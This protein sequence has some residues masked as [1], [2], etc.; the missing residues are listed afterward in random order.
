[1]TDAAINN[2]TTNAVS[3]SSEKWKEQCGTEKKNRLFHAVNE[4]RNRFL[5]SHLHFYFFILSVQ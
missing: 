2:A 4:M 3:N 1:V 5:L